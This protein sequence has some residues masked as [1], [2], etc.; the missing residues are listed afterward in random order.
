MKSELAVIQVGHPGGS[1][2]DEISKS[3]ELQKMPI[4]TNTESK[5]H[6]LLWQGESVFPRGI[7][8]YSQ[9]QSS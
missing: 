1:F 4:C 8:L 2:D 3:G 6:S 7:I 5:I 9:G